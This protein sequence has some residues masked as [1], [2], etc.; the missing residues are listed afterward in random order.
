MPENK[1]A[2]HIRRVRYLAHRAYFRV[3]IFDIILRFLGD[4]FIR[5]LP[6]KRFFPNDETICFYCFQGRE[7]HLEDV[8]ESKTQALNQSDR[9]LAQFRCRQAQA[10]AE[11][12]TQIPYN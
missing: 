4:A 8:I 5:G 9:L 3:Y 12:S 1:R 2:Y 6:S 7:R 11:V 10:D